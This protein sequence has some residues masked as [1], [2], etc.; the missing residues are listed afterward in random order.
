[1]LGSFN[2]EPEAV[3]KKLHDLNPG[4]TPGEDGWHPIFLKNITDLIIEPLTILFQKSLNEGVVP[5]QWLN[6]C[7][8]AI[9]KKEERNLCENYRPV[10][11]TSIICKLMESII[12]DKLVAHM[13]MNKLFFVL[14][15]AFSPEET[16]SLTY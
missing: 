7:I 15:T 8:T 10:S 11:I 12:R 1:M 16:V 5:P 4:K 3:Q 14:N 2:I 6:G 13:E 9:H